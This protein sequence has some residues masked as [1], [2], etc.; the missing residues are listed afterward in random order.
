[1]EHICFTDVPYF[2]ESSLSVSPFLIVW[3]F[4][5][6]E[7]LEDFDEVY[8]DFDLNLLLSAYILKDEVPAI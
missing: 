7:D 2:R 6:F 8:L 3:Y 5:D 1:M 4:E